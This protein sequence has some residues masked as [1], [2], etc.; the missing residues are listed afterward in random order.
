MVRTAR[1]G[2]TSRRLVA[3]TTACLVAGVAWGVL[4][5]LG[6]AVPKLSVLLLVP[7]SFGCTAAVTVVAARAPGLADTGRRFWRHLT[8]CVVLVAAGS[9]L[10]SPARLTP[11]APRALTLIQLS[12]P[13]LV[14]GILVLFYALLRLPVRARSPG[15][16]LRLGLDGMIVLFTTALF[17]WHLALRP[18]VQRHLDLKVV[19][20]LCIVTVTCLV[21]LVA[22][23]KVV[24]LG[25]GPVSGRSMG[26]LAS[27]MLLGALGAVLTPLI[28][29]PRW[30]GVQP[31]LTFT[32]SLLVATAAHVQYVTAVNPAAERSRTRPDRPYSKLPYFAGG[33]TLL[34]LAT[35]AYGVDHGD[36]A[37]VATGAVAVSGVVGVRQ[38][39][40]LRDNAQLLESVRRHE[41][42]L[43][44][45]ATHDALTGL[46]NRARFTDLLADA[47]DHG[48]GGVAVLLID[49][50]DFKLINDTHGHAVGDEVLITVARRL[51]DAVRAG[52]VVARLGGDE[53]AAVLY[54]ATDEHGVAVARRIRDGLSAA[55]TAGGHE[56]L[57]RASVGIA[58]SA[59]GD[60]LDTLLRNADLAMYGAK[61]RGKGDYFAYVPGM[62]TRIVAHAELGAQLREAIDAGQL[63]IEY[64]PIVRL[65]DGHI[66]GTE[67][68]VRWRHPERG[69]VPPA[70]FIPAAEQTGLVVPL[71]RWV[72]REACAQQSRWRQTL[73][74]AAP[75]SVGVN[76][77]GRQLTEPDFVATVGAALA[78]TGLDPRHLIIEV[79]ETAVVDAAATAALQALR[80]MR[81][82]IALDDFGTAA[83]SLGLLLTCPVTALKLDRTFV[84]RI[85]TVNR[86]EA[87]AMA[88][89]RMAQALE[90]DAVAEG[91][92]TEEQAVLLRNL[93]YRFGQGY[94]YGRPL[95]PDDLATRVAPA[96]S[97]VGRRTG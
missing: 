33:A 79:T 89:V 54:D 50:D 36:I 60:E 8:L 30:V 57:V 80:D 16:W 20:V 18:L 10:M 84:D 5:A 67:A 55:V 23:M 86:Q 4:H 73:G 76:V 68:L 61:E 22:V 93:G 96:L 91:I 87:V 3:A 65:C 24:M 45:Q 42:R 92:E 53:F 15:E 90:L 17:L 27:T 66:V 64:Q 83:S 69:I 28:D 31:V 19:L 71:G 9:S 56:L 94:L 52:D 49:L 63:F 74:A 97:S 40:A 88:V 13:L 85:T 77:A 12:A 7:V 46:V 2:R 41:Q 58:A 21:T 39:V 38:L 82:R 34:L 14:L 72:L 25:S 47:L 44:H 32:A 29:E 70:E 51:G 1:D 37:A 78:D 62:T 11:E 43:R 59:A 48:R 95:A 6:V 35:V 75:G 26:V 81:I